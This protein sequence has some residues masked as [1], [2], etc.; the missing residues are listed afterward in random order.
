MTYQVLC[1]GLSSKDI[2]RLEAYL[3]PN[4]MDHCSGEELLRYYDEAVC[5]IVD[6]SSLSEEQW[7]FLSE[8]RH[9]PYM[10]MLFLVGSQREEPQCF[11]KY[12]PDVLQLN[13]ENLTLRDKMELISQTRWLCWHCTPAPMDEVFRSTQWN[14]GWYLLDLETRGTDSSTGEILAVRMAYMSNYQ[15]EWEWSAQ[16]QTQNSPI[17][18]NIQDSI[19]LEELVRGLDNLEHTDAPLLL[20]NGN[21]VTDFLSHAYRKFGKRFT[22]EYLEIDNLAVRLFGYTFCREPDEIL[23]A[24]GWNRVGMHVLKDPILAGVYDL[25]MAA[26]REMADHYDVHCPGDFNTLYGEG[27]VD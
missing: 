7:Y 18:T 23:T 22:H 14:D 25:S 4:C 8:R 13:E 16:I 5:V 3:G 15:I 26:F 20:F 19:T 11:L 9:R 24:I 12:I 1:C 27:A 21:Y 6:P 2:S 10:P 17:E